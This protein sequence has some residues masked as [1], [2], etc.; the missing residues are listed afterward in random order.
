MNITQ[1]TQALRALG[2]HATHTADHGAPRIR[3]EHGTRPEQPALRAR[4]SDFVAAAP[5][6][7]FS[8][9]G[10]IRLLKHSVLLKYAL[11]SFSCR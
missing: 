7:S 3:V 1:L 10:M 9:T 8:C 6:S 2:F 5:I 11:S 4:P